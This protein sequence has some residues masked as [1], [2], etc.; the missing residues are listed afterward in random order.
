MRPKLSRQRAA[1][2]RQI[3]D[4][5]VRHGLGFVIGSA[6]LDQWVPFHHGLLGHDRRELPY[7]PPE[8]VRL[9]L[10]QLGP[11]FVKLGQVL[12]TRPD[13]LPAAYRE[14]L[15]ALQDSAPPV[16]GSLVADRIASELG[17]SPDEVFAWWDPVPL[18][19]ASIG[20]AHAARLSD[21]S[22]VVV[23]VRR[24][25][26]VAQIHRD[27]EILQDIAARAG[28]Q[29]EA[30]AAYDLPGI[31][32]DFA[33]TLTAELDYMTEGRHAERFAAN[34]AHDPAV[35]IPQVMWATTTSRVLTME[36]V[37]GIKVDDVAGLDAA[38]I[39]RSALAARATG[40]LAKMIFEDGFFHADPHP[41]NLFIEAGGRIGLIDFGMV[42]E[43]TGPLR[44]SLA[45]LLLALTAGSAGRVAAALADMSVGHADV[46][47]R[48]LT[49]DLVPV[50]ALYRDRPLGQVPLGQLIHQMLRVVAH[51]QLQ[52]PRE[53]A[54][55]FKM[56]V[57]AE[58]MG[59]TLDPQFQLAPVLGPYAQR[60][61]T[62]RFSAAALAQSLARGGADAAEL[63]AELPTLLHRVR[64]VL[65]SGGPEVHLRAAELEPLVQRVESVGRHLVAATLTAAVLRGLGDL[66]VAD[67]D[68][69][70]PWP[71][72]LL[73]VGLGAA[74]AVGSYLAWASR[75]P[76]RR[77]SAPP[78]R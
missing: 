68:R 55:L 47:Q 25:G 54:L 56:V 6:G 27:L 17:A 24:P 60:L 45:N 13:L 78:R 18:A 46:D 12:S 28:R 48:E 59:V 77:R 26:V 39:D 69:L 52:L 37:R 19:S 42:G 33:R 35:H 31:A 32:A 15:S 65:D 74:G 51:H 73:G 71:R 41:G 8:H 11:A 57:I 63:V 5:L 66:A 44:D 36:R 58:G 16:E 30:A 76:R 4:V 3:V 20:Q 75:R 40:V 22:D 62:R 49:R 67:P 72:S 50:V 34:F 29:W 9:A 21:G 61:T 10:E 2:Y 64:T 14:E 53:M 1:R 7:T 70:R 43:V 23:K 38:G